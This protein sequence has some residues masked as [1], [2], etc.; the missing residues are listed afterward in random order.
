MISYQSLQRPRKRDCENFGNLGHFNTSLYFSLLSVHWPSWPGL[1]FTK[2]SKNERRKPHNTIFLLPNAETYEENA[3]FLSTIL[4][5]PQKILK[6][7]PIYHHISIAIRKETLGLLYL[8][9]KTNG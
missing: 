7:I 9:F 6:K 2:T 4:S 8:Y 5:G 1:R 3:T